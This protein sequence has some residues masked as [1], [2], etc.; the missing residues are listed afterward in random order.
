MEHDSLPALWVHLL[1]QSLLLLRRS[2]DIEVTGGRPGRPSSP[3][4]GTAYPTD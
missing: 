4:S 1:L 3:L 2:I